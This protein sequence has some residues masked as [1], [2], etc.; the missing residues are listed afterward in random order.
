MKHQK[1]IFLI[2]IAILLASATP[3]LA[4]YL[5]PN[6]T[7][8]ETTSSCQIV[9]NECKYVSSKDD[10]RFKQVDT[11]SCS[12]E[13]KPWRA[14]PG[15]EPSQGCTSSSLGEKYWSRED[16]SRETTTTYPP[17]TISGILQNCTLSN[18]WC[19]TSPQLSLTGNEPVSGYQI[20]GIEGTLNSQLFACTGASCNV[21]LVE[22]TNNFT[23]WAHSSFTDTSE[24]GSLSAN[25]DAQPPMISSSTSGTLGSNGWYTSSVLFKTT[26]SDAATGVESFN[27][28]VDGAV[29]D[30]CYSVTLTG[31]GL[32]TIDLTAQDY[33]GHTRNV[34]RTTSIDTRPPALDVSVVG[35]RGKNTDW[36]TDIQINGTASDAL[37]G[38]G[39][40][41]LEYALDFGDWITFPS[42]GELSLRDGRH[43]VEVMAVDKA[44]LVSYIKKWIWVDRAAPILIVDASG[45]LGKNGWYIEKPYVSPT[46]WDE[47]SGINFLEYSLNNNLWTPYDGTLVLSDGINQISYWS[48]DNAGLVTRLDRTFKVDTRRPE[49]EGNLSGVSGENGWFTSDVT[50]SASAFD[51]QPASGIST[52]IYTLDGVEASY[53]DPFILTDGKHTV[54]LFAEDD[55][56]NPYSIDQTINI[57]TTPPSLDIQP[58]PPAWVKAD[59]TLAGIAD[60]DGSG[61]SKVEISTDGGQ[62]WQSVTG[63]SDWSFQWDTTDKTSGQY[64]LVVRAVDAAGLAT[65][66]TIKTGVD[67]QAPAINMSDSWFQWDTI[68]LDI[69]DE[70]SGISA[71]RLEISD[72]QNRWP[73]RIINLETAQFPM[74]FKWDRRFG[75][76][77]IAPAGTYNVKVF[78][79]DEVGNA[80]IKDAS[81]TVLVDILPP[82]P[83]ATPL[84]PQRPSPTPT[85]Y[86]P[87]TV[88]PTYTVTQSV[89]VKSFGSTSEP[90]LTPTPEVKITP[91]PRG[92][93]TQISVLEQLETIFRQPSTSSETV[94]TTETWSVEEVESASHATDQGSNVLWGATA[95]AVMG[96]LTAYA[97]EEKRKR[98]E[99]K[100]RQAELEKEEEERH[101]K[102]KAQKTAKLEAQWAQEQ[103]WEDAR[104]AEEERQEERYQA[105]METRLL[106][107]EIEEEEK[108]V[109][110]QQ[111]ERERKERERREKE[112]KKKAEE[113]QAAA[114]LA[115]PE[116]ACKA[117]E[118]EEPKE[119]SIWEKGLDWIDN[120]QTE[121]ALGLGVAVGIG[122]IILSG[123]IAAPAVALA[124]TAGAAAV[125]A[126]AAVAGTVA[127]N[128]HYDR[129]WNT[130]LGR[131]LAI[132]GGTALVVA[133]GWF[134][135]QAAST[136]IGAFCG[137]HKE[138]CS[139]VE[140]VFNAIDTGEEL[141]LTAKLAYQ[142]W[143]GDEEGESQTLLELQME[144]MDGGMPGN[145]VAKEFGID[146]L[147]AVA[148]YGDDAVDLVELYGIDAA[149]IILKYQD[150]GVE[151]L[152]NYGLNAIRLIQN[153]EDDAVKLLRIIKPDDAAKLLQSIDDD[154]L[155]Y[156]MKEGPDAVEAL[157]HWGP[158]DL[159]LHGIE[160]ALRSKDDA[161]AVAN[162]E[163]LLA[164]GPIDPKNLTDEQKALIDAIAEYS[165][166]Y[167][168]SGQVV[169]GKWV[170]Y[171][172]GFIESARETGSLHYA[173]HPDIY[174]KLKG[175]GKEE[176]SEVAWLVNQQVV[177]SGIDKNLPFEYSL[178]GIPEDKINKEMQALEAVFSGATNTQI[179]NILK[180]DYV[181]VRIK[182]LQT[183]Q[184]AG[185][186]LTFDEITNSYIL[187]QP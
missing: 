175:F 126:G 146:S 50:L 153:Y 82:G 38:S 8:T 127:L 9:L 56:G 32:H 182:E 142:R 64:D 46:T 72:P 59:L 88:V 71:S 148:K 184:K 155:E 164:S 168:D 177:Q 83:T 159:R 23:Y 143:R 152:Q 133:G 33:V 52:F 154:V 13:S 48:E 43:L 113:Q 121:I 107:R 125:A 100:A 141:S 103:A 134:L 145:A 114:A 95:A 49:I 29:P 53:T 22:G 76:D 98:E 42:S 31:E 25:V 5:G 166:Q 86:Y 1:I 137:I 162:V 102:I 69:Q 27:C 51:P 55:A 70:H 26:V 2:V 4:D 171:D 54:E 62:Y 92:T 185:Y 61:L 156:T 75:D 35:T 97:L 140:P 167:S 96:S 108:R 58:T 158:E 81:I 84:P 183:L 160:L 150:E 87:P 111:A 47:A 115:A 63:T 161:R 10:Y 65:S 151:L 34:T 21:P 147:S 45:T 116:A 24:M 169:L 186:E 12:L 79:E 7:V 37:P 77:T 176:G 30:S 118:Q 99:E 66:Q 90:V 36:Y 136:G 39:L 15:Q 123:G 28:T 124:W 173:P 89:V 130:N 16:I 19:T 93:P 131:N 157:S 109:A 179:M 174:T 41:T 119:K 78:A 144:H 163:K 122:A 172:S 181:P 105:S 180:T 104:E 91:T 6:R 101:E 139:R 57:D 14:Y 44:G 67:K 60:D 80:T 106:R 170:D 110:E 149:E 128:V 3:V 129:P 74:Q 17:A 20:I 40:S 138:A 132:A 68:T 73:A 165:K 94:T 11:W 117:P 112:A 120:H 187:V 85:T 135:L 18:G 178:N